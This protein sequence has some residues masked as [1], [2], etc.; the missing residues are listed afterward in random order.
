[1]PIGCEFICKNDKCNYHN[2]GFVITAPWP[3]AKIELILMSTQVS[4]NKQF[5]NELKNLIKDGKSLA[6][7]SFPNIDKIKTEAYRVQ[8]WS[9]KAKCIWE[10]NVAELPN[11]NTKSNGEIPETCPSTGCKLLTFHEVM[12]EGIQCPSCGENLQRNSWFTKDT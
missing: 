8:M 4:E 10:Y 12:E 6:C 11:K 1:M 7:I 9:P 5:K 2:T 3:M